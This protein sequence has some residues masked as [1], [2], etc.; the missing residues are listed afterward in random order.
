LPDDARKLLKTNVAMLRRMAPEQRANMTKLAQ[1][2]TEKSIGWM[3]NLLAQAIMTWRA[4]KASL[5]HTPP[6]ALG[7][8]GA[9]PAR[10]ASATAS[11]NATA[12]KPT[13]DAPRQAWEND[14]RQGR[15]Q[16]G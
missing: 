12:A 7:A 10:S 3:L 5:Q 6:K 4:K 16:L 15:R 14:G 1:P 11:S 9:P 8:S 13:A 2:G